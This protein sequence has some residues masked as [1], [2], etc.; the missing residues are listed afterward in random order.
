MIYRFLNLR[1]ET[2]AGVSISVLQMGVSWGYGRPVTSQVSSRSSITSYFEPGVHVGR[3]DCSNRQ[4]IS[5]GNFELAY[6]LE[7]SPGVVLD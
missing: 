7:E 1:P 6:L 4:T 5:I 2:S 3:S